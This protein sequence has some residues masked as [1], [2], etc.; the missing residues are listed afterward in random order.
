[1]RAPPIAEY[2]P[3][4]LTLPADGP[5]KVY[6]L[7]STGKRVKQVQASVEGGKVTLAPKV[8]DAAVLFEVS[9]E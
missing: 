6:A 2:V 8:E 4:R 7:D 1:M 9:A 3:A 5:R